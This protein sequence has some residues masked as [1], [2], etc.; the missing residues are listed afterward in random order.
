L[1][2]LRVIL[3]TEKRQKVKFHHILNI[4]FLKNILEYAP[5]SISADEI[6]V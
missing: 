2:T 6:R 5:K 3:L 4:I 1:Y